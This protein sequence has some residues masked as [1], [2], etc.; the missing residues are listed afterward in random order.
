MATRLKPVELV[1]A[2][3]IARR[4]FV[5]GHS[6]VRI[7]E[8]FGLTRFKVARSLEEARRSGLVRIE[9]GL[10]AELDA[11]LSERL[12][13]R[14]GLRHALVITTPAEPEEALRAH[15][16]EV[17]A[18]LLSEIVV[19]GDVLGIGWGRT[20]T[21]MTSALDSLARCTVVQL[22]GAVGVLGVRE[23]SVETVRAVAEVCGGPA[24]PIYAPLVLDDPEAAAAI[25]RQ[26]HVAEALRRFDLLTK[27]VV[28]VG[29]WDPPNSQLRDALSAQDRA[30]LLSRRVRAEICSTLVDDDGVAVAPDMAERSIAVSA[31]QL[32][33][34]PEVIAVAGGRNKALAVRAVLRAGMVTSLVTDVTV[35]RSL[36]ATEDVAQDKAGEPVGINEG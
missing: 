2:G 14:F 15:L 1:R 30:A 5:E 10:P 3:T 8:E 19:E 24:F 7:G 34:V 28:A 12:R 32:R 16:G 6:K 13:D 17:A 4:Y 9:I 36:L 18:G 21:A 11:E 33:R 35:G 31:A 29:S 27:A 20:L 26:P 25:R 23:D 22:T